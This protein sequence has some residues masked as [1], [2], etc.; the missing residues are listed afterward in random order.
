MEHSVD[1]KVRI[2]E[3]G[4]TIGIDCISL[5]SFFLFLKDGNHWQTTGSVLRKQNLVFF[6]LPE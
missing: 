4:P 6:S 5:P 2:A 3:T 1:L